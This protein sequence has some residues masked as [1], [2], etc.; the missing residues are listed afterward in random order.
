MRCYTWRLDQ[1]RLSVVADSLESAKAQAIEF[2]NK[3]SDYA[4]KPKEA[5]EFRIGEI[6]NSSPSV[7][8]SMVFFERWGEV[9]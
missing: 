3:N 4:K 8:D 1:A 6:S 5:R 2:F 7:H 9:E